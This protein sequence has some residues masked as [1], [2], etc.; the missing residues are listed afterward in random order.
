MTTL[1][2][3]NEMA[4]A[5]QPGRLN[6]WLESAGDRLNPILV[7]ETRQSLKSRQFTLWFVL[8]LIGCWVTTI[9]AI[10]MVGPSI[11]YVSAGG[12]LLY[13]YYVILALPLVVVTPFSAY[14]SLSSEHEDNTRDLLEVSSLSP[15]QVINGKLGSALL[16]IVIYLSA[17]APCIAFTYLLRGVD[18]TTIGLLLAYAVLASIGLSA[19]GLVIAAAT[20]QKYAQVVMSVGFA[21]LL[22]LAYSGLLAAAAAVRGWESRWLHS[23]ENWWLHL[24]LLCLYATSFG[25]VYTAA[26]SLTTFT[27]AN[28]STGLRKAAFIQQAFFVAWIGGAVAAGAPYDGVFVALVVA[29]VY[30]FAAGALM[31]GEAPLLSLRVRRSLPTSL[32]GRAVRSWFSPGSGSGY[33]FAVCNVATLAL[34]VVIAVYS[35]AIPGN[36]A[37]AQTAK[38]TFLLVS[39]FAAYLGL[40]RLAVDG[41]R[42]VT[43]MST[44]GGFL[45]QVLFALFG[46]GLPFVIRTLSERVRVADWLAITASSPSWNVPRVLNGELPSDVE[47]T[48]L[49]AVGAVAMAVFLVNLAMAGY[50][51]RQMRVAIPKRVLEDDRELQPE[52]ESRVTNPW[53]DRPEPATEAS[54]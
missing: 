52:P 49:I 38:A 5:A 18:L 35:T 33:V 48:L 17:L 13:V 27:A 9:G 15:R 30:W 28:R 47:I 26:I 29:A 11:Y 43:D 6:R 36:F 3:Q 16:Q 10:A 41:L 24:A 22:F 51:A 37:P 54:R 39:Y 31:S 21:G 40:G 32:L 2:P 50:E 19:V 4:D 7:K 12:Y 44:L 1:P 34:M 42:R 23:E 25:V 46:S 14:R 53:G 45:I 20:R 8:L